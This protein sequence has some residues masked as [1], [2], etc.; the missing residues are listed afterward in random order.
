MKKRD[1]KKS[2][3]AGQLAL[4]ALELFAQKGYVATSLEEISTL[5]GIGKST[6]YEYYRT[7]EDLFIA[8]V[9]EASDQWVADL[10]AVG[11]ET[12]DAV[13]RLQRIAAIHLECLEPANKG[14][15][16]IFLEV[17]M[18][19]FMAGGVFYNRRH[20]ILEIHH[21]VV[22]IIVDFLLD[23]ISSGQL[24]PGIARDAEKI[25]VNF[26]AFLD[27]IQLHAML[28]DGY[29]DPHQQVANYM[30]HLVNMLRNED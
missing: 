17:L 22:K 8:A 9:M 24:R 23:G 14:V 6:V 20:L 15:I 16:R 21:R 2:D 26:L 11:D 4:A 10:M 5:A 19:T 25:A 29:F 18:Q 3:K 7:K 13:E 30:D 1:T 12:E 27:G 28:G